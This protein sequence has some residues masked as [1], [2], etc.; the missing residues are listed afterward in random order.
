M[1]SLSNCTACTGHW[2]HWSQ[3]RT[4][5]TWHANRKR[6]ALHAVCTCTRSRL[7]NGHIA[8]TGPAH[9]QFTSRQLLWWAGRKESLSG[10]KYVQ[11]QDIQLAI[12]S[13]VE[14]SPIAFLP[15]PCNSCKRAV[16][17]DKNKPCTRAH[18]AQAYN[19]H[20]TRR[21]KEGIS[22]KMKI[23]S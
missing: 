20:T 16:H 19:T 14:A 11:R 17:T 1:T 4:H 10:H 3:T 22:N 12:P 21:D 15:L 8:Q 13:P 6:R 2:T 5:I 9:T 18:T 7:I 23:T